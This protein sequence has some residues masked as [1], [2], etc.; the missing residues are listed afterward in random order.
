VLFALGPGL[1]AAAFGAF[2]TS[3]IASP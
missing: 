3:G 2:V 1:R